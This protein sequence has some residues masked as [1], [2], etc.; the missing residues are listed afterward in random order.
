MPPRPVSGV[1]LGWG[2][3]VDQY[4]LAAPHDVLVPNWVPYPFTHA[5]TAPSGEGLSILILQRRKLRPGKDRAP[6]D[7]DPRLPE[8]LCCCLCHMLQEAIERRMVPGHPEHRPPM[9]V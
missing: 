6:P 2:W 7:S 8:S 9:V 5:A 1:G 4:L 3:A